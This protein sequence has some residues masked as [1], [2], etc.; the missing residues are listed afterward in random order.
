M[1]ATLSAAQELLPIATGR[2]SLISGVS[3][4]LGGR[5]AW[6]YYE[7]SR[8]ERPL[9]IARRPAGRSYGPRSADD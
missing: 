6:Y 4:L 9:L 3:G 8:G 5:R 7:I 2:A 1:A